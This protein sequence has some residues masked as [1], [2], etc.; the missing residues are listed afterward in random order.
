[1]KK[2]IFVSF[3]A[4]LLAA[5]PSHAGFIMKKH[6]AAVAAANS[7]TGNMATNNTVSENAPAA[8]TVVLTQ[9]AV[10]KQ[11]VVSKMLDDK[12]SN[13]EIPKVLYIVLSIIGFGWLAMGVNDNFEDWD[14]VISLILT[15]LAWLPG[16]IY[17]LIKMKKYYK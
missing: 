9:D 2:L 5:T 6:T 8:E 16:V 14:W 3:T 12:S 4:C 13:A 17:S 1:M 10:T 15:I 11:T 7:V